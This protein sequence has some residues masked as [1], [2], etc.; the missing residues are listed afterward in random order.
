MTDE[1]ALSDGRLA[2]EAPPFYTSSLPFWEMP[3]SLNERL[4]RRGACPVST[5]CRIPCRT[6]CRSQGNSAAIPCDCAGNSAPARSQFRAASYGEFL[7]DP[8]LMAVQWEMPVTSQHLFSL[9]TTKMP[10]A[11]HQ[12]PPLALLFR[13]LRCRLWALRS[14][15]HRH[16]RQFSHHLQSLLIISHSSFPL[17]AALSWSS[18]KATPTTDA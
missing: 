18:P 6:P 15:A 8:N 4:G 1:Q 7:A 5:P 10:I 12:S 2:V 11:S 3:Q 13:R 9:L 16:R 17:I 14:A